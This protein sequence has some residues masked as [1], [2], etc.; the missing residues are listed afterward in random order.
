MEI[1]VLYDCRNP[2]RW[3]TD[4]ALLY[5]DVLG[6]AALVEELGFD[7]VWLTEHHFVDDGYLPS[8]LPLAAAIAAR[9]RRV[10][11]GTAVLLL[12]LHDPLRVAEDVAVV[13]LI[14]GGR[15]RLGVGLGYRAHEL[16]AF[17]VQRSSRASRLEEAVDVLR[18]AWGDGP[19]RFEGRHYQ[20]NGIDVTP[21]PVQRP[22]PPIWFA[23]RS[24]RPM[25]RAARLG[26]G[27]IAPSGHDSYRAYRDELA[28][29]GRTGPVNLAAL[30]FR[31]PSDDPERDA[32]RFEP[33]L[34]YRSTLYNQWYGEA[35]DLEADRLRLRRQRADPIVRAEH[36]FCTV[37]EM[38][39]RLSAL[40]D[41]GFTSI[42]WFATLPGAAVHALTPNL[43]LLVERVMPAL[44]RQ[45]APT[46]TTL[47]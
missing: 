36:F 33:H 34:L 24:A 7:T 18:L 29:V 38:T 43:A 28:K 37:E 8:C 31:I 45:G 27:L 25:E 6:H 17:G 5:A 44:Q 19:V 41:T 12:P 3:R 22:G 15:L 16:E 42:I 39:Q 30:E 32:V 40:A 2:A 46:T 26:D 20:Y 1:G 23:G 13:D 4:G 47:T 10:T 14:S 11:L 21:K 9:T 35:G